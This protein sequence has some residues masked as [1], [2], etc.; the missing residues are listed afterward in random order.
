MHTEAL[1]IKACEVAEKCTYAYQIVLELGYV[2]DYAETVLAKA[3]AILNAD[4]T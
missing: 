3:F 1:R 2:E 4:N